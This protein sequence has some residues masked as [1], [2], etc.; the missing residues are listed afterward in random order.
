MLS[1]VVENGEESEECPRRLWWIE[2]RVRGG[3]CEWAVVV[4]GKMSGR[5]PAWLRRRCA[6]FQVFKTYAYNRLS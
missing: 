5:R 6:G 4:V 1:E 2:W 3:G